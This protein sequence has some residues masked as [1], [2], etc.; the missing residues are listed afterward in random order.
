MLISG[1]D[2]ADTVEERTAVHTPAANDD[3]EKEIK[4]QSSPIEI[5][6]G[7]LQAWAT[8]LGA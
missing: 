4:E 5:P 1:K 3:L 6:D 8:V 2:A 7:G